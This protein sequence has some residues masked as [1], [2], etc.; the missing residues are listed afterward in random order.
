[1]GRETNHKESEEVIEIAKQAAL[2][3]GVKLARIKVQDEEGEAS[4]EAYPGEP[5]KHEESEF[6]KWS[7]QHSKYGVN[8][9]CECEAEVRTYFCEGCSQMTSNEVFHSP[10]MCER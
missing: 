1:M 4:Y 3:R 10:P 9:C 5:C 2:D 8:V 6:V 7:W